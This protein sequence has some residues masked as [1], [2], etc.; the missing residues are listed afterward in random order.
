MLAFGARRYGDGVLA[1]EFRN[2]QDA[3][4]EGAEIVA[5]VGC[6]L[7]GQAWATVFLRA[8]AQVNLFDSVDGAAARAAEEIEKRLAELHDFGLA[9]KG[10]TGKGAGSLH[11]SPTLE[12]A[13]AE[14][15]YIQENGPEDLAIKT[16]LTQEIAYHA[17]STA[18]IGSSTSGLR[19]SLY[20]ETVKGRERC[21]VVHPINPPHL[22]PLVEVVPSKWTSQHVVENVTE[23]L[24]AVEQVPIALAKEIDGFVVNRLQ[25]ALLKEAFRLLDNGI[26]TS[27]AIDK[28][29]SR[30]LGM[31]WS[32]MGP[33][34]T[35]HLNAPGGV[36]DYVQRFGPMYKNMF[37]GEQQDSDWQTVV[38]AGL[39][40]DLTEKCPLTDITGAQKERDTALMQLLASRKQA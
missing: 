38:D 18:P 35:I 4:S 34:E 31:R 13:V 30:G 14:A 26:A 7:I 33:F 29:I 20:A 15:D 5:I 6:G 24:E 27:D 9:S 21:L 12:D 2:P 22:V 16:A 3:G 36:A 28:A 39:E 25:G 23:L 40:A 10:S 19:A 37:A 8:G 11:V 17:P 1:V 32:L